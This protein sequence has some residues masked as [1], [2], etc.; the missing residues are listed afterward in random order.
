MFSS[1]IAWDFLVSYT[2]KACPFSQKD[3]CNQLSIMARKLGDLKAFF[4]P[5]SETMSE[6]APLNYFLSN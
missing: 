6:R 3:N 4:S 1:L 5:T 2:K